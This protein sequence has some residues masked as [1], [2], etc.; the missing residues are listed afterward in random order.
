MAYDGA[1]IL[2][3]ETGIMCRN[4]DDWNTPTAV[5]GDVASRL[6]YLS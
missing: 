4:L 1:W 3:K 5:S 6:I 2:D